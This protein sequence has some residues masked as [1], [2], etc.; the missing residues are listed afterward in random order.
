MQ[1]DVDRADGMDPEAAAPEHVATVPVE[2]L[3]DDRVE[4]SVEVVPR[5][6]GHRDRDDLDPLDRAH[7]VPSPERFTSSSSMMIPLGSLR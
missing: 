3:D 5:M 4:S 6:A 2:H 1:R 7:E